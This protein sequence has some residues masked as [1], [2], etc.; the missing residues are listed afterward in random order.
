MAGVLAIHMTMFFP[1]TEAVAEVFEFGKRGVQAFFA[2]SAY[3]GCSY[4]FRPNPNTLAYYK[5][6]AL[7][8]L[9]TYYAA[10]VAAIVYVEIFAGGSTP[11]MFHLGWARYFLGLNTILPSNDFSQWNNCMAFWSLTDFI[12]FYLLAPL[13]FKLVRTYKAAIIFL[14]G[15]V[16]LAYI[17]KSCAKLVP[18]DYFSNIRQFAKWTP[19]GQMQSFALGILVYFAIKEQKIK[20][21]AILLVLITA[22][23]TRSEMMGA[24]LACLTI[25]LVK[26]SMIALSNG[27]TKVVKFLS[28]YSF[29]VYL[30]HM[31]GLNIATMVATA[32]IGES[33]AGFYWVKLLM[34][35]VSIVTLCGILEGTQLLAN[36]VFGRK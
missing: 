14:I 27:W 35:I 12:A 23:S 36:R 19:L 32:W 31:L 13:I 3:L 5:R 18:S 17:C 6:R 26:D 28:H 10:I 8:I 4:F 21:T 34:A 9:P 25:L 30:T 29:H 24:S 2:L 22:V 7:R 33:G 15:C 11:D 20:P 16:I 1:V